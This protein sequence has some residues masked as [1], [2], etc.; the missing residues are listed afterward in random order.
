VS[1]ESTTDLESTIRTRLLSFAPL[2]GNGTVADD[3]GMTGTGSGIGGKL[4]WG[5]APDDIDARLS[6]ST[7]PI[8]WGVL[9]LKNRRSDN[10]NGEREQM[11]LEV[12]LF[13]RP[14]NQRVTL[15]RIADTMDAAMLRWRDADNGLV[16]KQDR[17][18]HSL[19][20]FKEPA[21]SDIVQIMLEYTLVVWRADLIQYHDT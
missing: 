3:L 7:D 10:E 8:R 21:D 4:F 12:T 11:E 13:G 14:W 18:R 16:F 15:E 1:T 19:P 17:I 2:N 5:R 20:P 9:R 6:G